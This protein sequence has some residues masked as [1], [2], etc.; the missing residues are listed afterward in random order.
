LSQQQL[1]QQGIVPILAQTNIIYKL[2]LYLG[3]LVLVEMWITELK[4]ASVILQFR[5]Y[6]ARGMLA[7]EGWQKAL[8]LDKQTMRPRRFSPQARSS[9]MP[10]IHFD[11]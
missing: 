5:S 1:F 8:F 2:P 4:N 3:D 11:K 9:F 6:N 10:Y 7:A